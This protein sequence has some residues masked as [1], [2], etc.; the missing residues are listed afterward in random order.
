[1]M[2]KNIYV[3]LLDEGIRVFRP[4]LATK[5]SNNVYK[6][7]ESNIYDQED[8]VWE[9]PPG[10]RVLVEEEYLNDDLELVAVSRLHD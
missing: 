9:F 5:L 1:M 10:T 7:D 8:E 6:I 3:L 4:V 2:K